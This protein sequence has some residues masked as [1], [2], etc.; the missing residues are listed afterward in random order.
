M[1][2]RSRDISLAPV[3]LAEMHKNAGNIENDRVPIKL[4]IRQRCTCVSDIRQMNILIKY[5]LLLVEK[6]IC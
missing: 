2:Y 5:K 1:S 3:M 6:I 4:S